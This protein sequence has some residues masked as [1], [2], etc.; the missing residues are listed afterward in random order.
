MKDQAGP[1]HV[2]VGMLKIVSRKKDILDVRDDF[3]TI[4]IKHFKDTVK[5]SFT[6]VRER[7]K[8]RQVFQAG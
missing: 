3:I 8:I 4:S 6:E 5:R 1:V 7:G 2:D